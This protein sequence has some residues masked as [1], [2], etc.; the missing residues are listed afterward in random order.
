M[1]KK[2]NQKNAK[3]RAFRIKSVFFM[4]TP[5]PMHLSLHIGDL[6]MSVCAHLKGMGEYQAYLDLIPISNDAEP[7]TPEYWKGF[8][9]WTAVGLE[10]HHIEP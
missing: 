9:D 1:P 2:E 3:L 10:L 8:K 5:V 6:L 7:F 4:V